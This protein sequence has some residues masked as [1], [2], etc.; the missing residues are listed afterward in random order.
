MQK[1]KN[2]TRIGP[3]L[4]WL[5]STNGANER[6]WKLDKPV[7]SL[8]YLIEFRTGTQCKKLSKNGE[9]TFKYLLTRIQINFGSMLS[10]LTEQNLTPRNNQCCSGKFVSN[11][12]STNAVNC[13]AE[14]WWYNGTEMASLRAFCFRRTTTQRV[15]TESKQCSGSWR[16]L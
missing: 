11:S 10:G 5:N 1:A 14:F 4:I 2:F 3:E 8:V 12:T 9:E 6:S 7:T 13:P 15:S 16:Q